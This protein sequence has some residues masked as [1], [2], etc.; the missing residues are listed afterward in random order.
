MLVFLHKDEKPEKLIQ[1]LNKKNLT[2]NHLLRHA[3]RSEKLGCFFN[4]KDQTKLK[5]NNY[6]T[7]LVKCREKTFSE[8]YLGETA[9]RI[10]KRVLEHAGKNKKSHMLRHAL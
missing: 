6:L 7:Y 8:N 2:K 9:T 4:I 3:Y 5:Q 10:N 1:S